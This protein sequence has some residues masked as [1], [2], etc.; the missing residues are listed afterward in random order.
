MPLSYA[1]LG[2]RFSKYSDANQIFSRGGGAEVPGG[3]SVIRNFCRRAPTPPDKS[4]TDA[5]NKFVDGG[6]FC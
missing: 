6:F 4:A 2:S 3:C 1:T 5:N